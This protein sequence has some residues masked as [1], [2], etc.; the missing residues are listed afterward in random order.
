MGPV[1]NTAQE[2]CEIETFFLRLGLRS[3]LIR[4]ENG[5]MSFSNFSCAVRTEKT[6]MGFQSDVAIFKL[7]WCNVDAAYNEE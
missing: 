2:K 1:H 5:F 6:L 3:T 7:L 4:R